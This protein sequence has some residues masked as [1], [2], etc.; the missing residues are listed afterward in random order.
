[1]EVGAA[2]GLLG[3][4]VVDGAE[5]L[6][7]ITGRRDSAGSSGN[8]DELIHEVSGSPH[9]PRAHPPRLGIF[10]LILEEVLNMP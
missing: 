3:Q 2:T 4:A 1:V 8:F 6:L 9:L 10:N 5:R 7:E